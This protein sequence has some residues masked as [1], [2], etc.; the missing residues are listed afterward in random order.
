MHYEMN[1][2][3]PFHLVDAAGIVFFGQPFTLAHQIF[4]QF[5]VKK[6]NISWKNWFYNSEWIVPIVH[7]EADFQ[8]PIHAGEE[9]LVKLRIDN[10]STSSFTLK[11]DFYQREQL[12]C[13]IKTVHVFCDRSTHLK[14]DIPLPIR[15][16][17]S[18]IKPPLK[19]VEV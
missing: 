4:E 10:I 5:V 7:S 18:A 15:E 9:C 14:K 8:N 11:Y 13:S 1:V 6:L 3:I 19:P 2:F 16:K 17:L 12:C